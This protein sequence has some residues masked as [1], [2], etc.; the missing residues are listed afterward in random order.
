MPGASETSAPLSAPLG[1]PASVTQVRRAKCHT[2]AP[3]SAPVK[4]LPLARLPGVTQVRPLVVSCLALSVCLGLG[5][6][7]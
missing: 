3:L 5:G 6:P 2:G 7:S 1:A 4:L